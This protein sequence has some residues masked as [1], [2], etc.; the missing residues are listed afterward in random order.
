MGTNSKTTI[1]RPKRKSSR[2]TL[3]IKNCHQTEKEQNRKVRKKAY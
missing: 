1:N 3:K 2:N